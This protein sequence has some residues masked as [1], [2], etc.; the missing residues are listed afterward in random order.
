[1]TGR[2]EIE[3]ARRATR[4][5]TWIETPGRASPETHEVSTTRN[6]ARVAIGAAVP[7]AVR[8]ARAVAT[9]EAVLVAAHG[10]AHEE[11]DVVA[12]DVAS[13]PSGLR[14]IE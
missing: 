13:L 3:P 1:M 7:G 11:E 5:A 6:S 8:V 2:I 14:E 12:A 9:T 10:V 4:A